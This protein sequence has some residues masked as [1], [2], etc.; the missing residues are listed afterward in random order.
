MLGGNIVNEFHHVY[1]FTDT[2]AAEQSDLAAFGK[3]AD[4][5]DYLD[6]GFK[7]FRRRAQVRKLGRLPVDTPLFI[8]ID[9][10]ALIDWLAQYVH[11]AS[12][13]LLTHRDGDRRAGIVHLK[14][15]LQPVRGTQGNRS[16][17]PVAQLLLYFESGF[18]TFGIHLQR[19]IDLRNGVTGKFHVNYRADD[20]YNVSSTHQ[21]F[22]SYSYVLYTYTAAAP[23]TISEISWVIAAWRALL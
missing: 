8:G 11:D 22:S 3:G 20:L 7:Q 16:H 17:H 12:Q 23:P 14:T 4:Q 18:H 6:T 9:C 1:R 13:G 19:V 10:A 15:P 2:G 5:V 21:F